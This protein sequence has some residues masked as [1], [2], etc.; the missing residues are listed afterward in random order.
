MCIRDRVRE[1]L[2]VIVDL[3]AEGKTMMIVTHEMQFAK[4]IADRVIFIDSGS[5]VEEGAPEA[6]FESPK[7]ERAKKFLQTFTFEDVSKRRAAASDS[8][9]VSE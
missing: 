4:A 5:I 6:F 3:A 8:I 9:S 2:D 7:T 1:V